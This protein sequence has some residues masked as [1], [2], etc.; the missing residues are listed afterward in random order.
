[1]AKIEKADIVVLSPSAAARL[2][3]ASG[4]YDNHLQARDLYYDVLSPT[5]EGMFWRINQPSGDVLLIRH[6]ADTLL[7]PFG[8]ELEGTPRYDWTTVEDGVRFGTYR[9]GAAPEGLASNA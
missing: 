8:H 9:P 1:V 4:T 7:F 3:T 5:H 6:P 2:L